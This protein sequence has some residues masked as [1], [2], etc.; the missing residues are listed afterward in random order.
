[1]ITRKTLFNINSFL[2]IRRYSQT[3]ENISP[4]KSQLSQAPPLK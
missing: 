4:S 3:S 2:K 1:M